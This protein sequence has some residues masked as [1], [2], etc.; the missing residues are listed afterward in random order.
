[1][2]GRRDKI[3]PPRLRRYSPYR[4]ESNPPLPGY[5]GTPHYG[6]RKQSPLPGYAG[7]PPFGGRN[8]LTR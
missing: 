1:M 7:T 5:A 3:P 2:T 4:G 8:V 6:G